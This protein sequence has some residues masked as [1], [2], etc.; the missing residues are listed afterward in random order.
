[1]PSGGTVP[2]LFPNF[3]VALL[4]LDTP[5]ISATIRVLFQSYSLTSKLS[6]KKT[7]KI[8]K[9]LFILDIISLE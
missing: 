9:L 7:S 5:R 4:A 1:M 3:S 8:L 6:S 2:C